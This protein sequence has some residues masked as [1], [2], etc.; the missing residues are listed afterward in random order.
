MSILQRMSHPT[1]PDAR[2]ATLRR[3]LD[4]RPPARAVV[5]EGEPAEAYARQHLAEIDAARFAELIE[6]LEERSDTAVRESTP[7]EDLAQRLLLDDCA[8][9][10][11][12]LRVIATA[13]G[14]TLDRAQTTVW[15]GQR[16]IRRRAPGE[17]AIPGTNGG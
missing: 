17:G 3:L 4:G 14:T 2:L 15:E 1:P 12:R 5:P 11:R 13:T 8:D 6:F 9:A 16:I 7:A 10:I